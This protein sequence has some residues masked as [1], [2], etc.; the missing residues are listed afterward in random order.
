MGRVKLVCRSKSPQRRLDGRFR[1]AGLLIAAFF[2]LSAHLGAQNTPTFK[3]VVGK[4][5]VQELMGGCSLTCAFPWNA[6][7]GASSTLKI[8]ALNDSDSTTA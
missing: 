3:A 8:A 1:R 7:A 2:G 4:P 6:V 5:V